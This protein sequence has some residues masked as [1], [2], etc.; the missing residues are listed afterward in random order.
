[1]KITVYINK[2][3]LSVSVNIENIFIFEFSI[4]LLFIRFKLLLFDKDDFQKY[5]GTLN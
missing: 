3:K 4:F 1:M 5:F 2:Y